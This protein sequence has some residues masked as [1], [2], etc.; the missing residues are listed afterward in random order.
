MWSED[1]SWEHH[2]SIEGFTVV[3]IFY[4]LLIRDNIWQQWEELKKL[5]WPYIY[6]EL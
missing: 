6:G 2:G 5:V 1:R 4:I 3:Q